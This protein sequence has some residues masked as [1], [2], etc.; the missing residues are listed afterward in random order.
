MIDIS[1]IFNGRAVHAFLDGRKTLPA[2][3]I[4]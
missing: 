2:F 4:W 1:D 3:T